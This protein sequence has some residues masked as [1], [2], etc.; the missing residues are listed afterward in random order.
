MRPG[1]R[2]TEPGGA[3]IRIYLAASYRRRQ[4]L[5][6][7]ADDLKALGHEVTSHWLDGSHDWHGARDRVAPVGEQSL[8]AVE[9]LA[10]I[11]RADALFLFT[12]HSDKP[13]RG[14]A[15]AEFGYALAKGKSIAVIGPRTHVFTCL[16]Y[17]KWFWSWQHFLARV[18]PEVTA[19]SVDL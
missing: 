7:Y 10:D 6:L 13:S 8:W 9:D 1:C 4:E 3:V 11:D 14:G 19:G 2:E 16:P 15:S 5:C 18:A 17:V 12:E